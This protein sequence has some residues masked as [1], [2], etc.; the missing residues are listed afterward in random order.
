[1]N[2]S[3]T[4]THFIGLQ[5]DM[6]SNVIP[7]IPSFIFQ[8]QLPADSKGAVLPMRSYAEPKAILADHNRVI[9]SRLPPLN[10]KTV[11]TH[12]TSYLAELRNKSPQ[13]VAGPAGQ[14]AIDNSPDMTLI[15]SSRG[16]ILYVSPLSLRRL[17]G[18][19]AQRVVGKMVDEIFHSGDSVALLRSLKEADDGTQ[20]EKVCRMKRAD[21]QFKW[22]DVS[23]HKYQMQNKKATKC[24]IMSIRPCEEGTLDQEFLAHSVDLDAMIIKVTR[25][26]VVVA[27]F[28]TC[29]QPDIKF[30]V[31]TNLL[32]LV[33]ANDHSALSRVLEQHDV[34]GSPPILVILHT[35]MDSYTGLLYCSILRYSKAYSYVAISKTDPGPFPP[36]S[37][38][39]FDSLYSNMAGAIQMELEKIEKENGMLKSRIDTQSG[40]LLGV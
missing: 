19:V 33:D 22:S 6:S 21:G 25:Q 10:S 3:G 7:I 1:M 16:I 39:V 14:E 35:Q 24:Y 17:F 32:S 34:A 28:I 23:G 31:G 13:V 36:N 12:N 5:A 8:N 37:G 26:A 11:S 15:I 20:V 38:N 2:T 29:D 27:Q 18:H 40:L 9:T 30:P 4:I